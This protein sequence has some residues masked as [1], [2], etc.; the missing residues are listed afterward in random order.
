M[1]IFRQT[2]PGSLRYALLPRLILLTLLCWLLLLVGPFTPRLI[3]QTQVMAQTTVPAPTVPF[4]YPDWRI[5]PLIE[6]LTVTDLKIRR[7]ATE[8]LVKIGAPAVPALMSALQSP[9]ATLRWMAASVIGDMGS[10]AAAAVPALIL[11]LQDPDPQVRLYTTIALGNIGPA[12]AAAIPELSVSLQDADP[13]VRVYAPLA[14]RKMGAA[15]KGVIPELIATLQDTNGRVRLNAAYALGEMGIEAVA[16]LPSLET[17]LSDPLPYVRFGA[18]KGLAGIAQGFQDQ[19]EQLST[20][21]L[22]RVI[23]D[24]T[25]VLKQVEDHPERFPVSDQVYLRRPLNALKAEQDSRFLG[26]LQE[27]VRKNR[28]VLGGIA[29]LIGLPSLWFAM[30]RFAPLRL[31]QLN[32]A[33]RPY[34]DLSLPVIG[35][36]LPLRFVLFLS[37]F[38]YHPRVLDAWVAESVPTVR[39]QFAQK[40][41][42]K[43]RACY[44]PLPVSLGEQTLPTLQLAQLR[45]IFE[46]QRSCLVIWGEGGLGKTSLACQIAQLALAEQPEQ[47]LCPHLMLPVLIEE[48]LREVEGKSALLEAIRGQLQ[49]LMDA[50]EPLCEELLLRL[51]RQRRILVIIDRFSELSPATQAAVQ[52][53]SPAFPINALILT[54]QVET[55]LGR[56]NKTSLTPQRLQPSQ[57][58]LFLRDYLRVRGGGDLT[59]ATSQ[60][61][62]KAAC[63]D[64]AQWLGQRSTTVLL[65]KLYAE[66]YLNCPSPHPQTAIPDLVLSYLNELNQDLT[67]NRLDNRTLHQAAKALAWACVQTGYTLQPIRRSEALAVLD[68][69]AGVLSPAE[70]LDYLEHRLKLVETIGVAQEQLQFGLDPLAM[71]LAAL[72]LTEQLG[73]DE[74]KWRNQFFKRVDQLLETDPPE[75]LQ[76]FIWTVQACYRSQAASMLHPTSN[77]PSPMVEKKLL[78]LLG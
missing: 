34:T 7:S 9:D 15:A 73:S 25:Q 21:K 77:A 31:L 64:F 12:A 37:W 28:W 19:A 54:S 61:S 40:Q 23:L 16:A 46:R 36:N 41:T 3:A 49:M 2:H 58:P 65:V 48:D 47:R 11:A 59:Q 6:K 22:N 78:G 17:L 71:G 5:V 68:L 44:V 35:L 52:P 1:Q 63:Q 75:T 20:L 38:H 56:V 62:F 18:L 66:Q 57:I 10:D 32:N 33:L 8:A 55:A 4:A 45:P 76:G 39:Q 70:L 53:E 50:A 24:F 13:M 30:L 72:L 51:L 14:L 43:D 74:G 42:V 60:A 27:W 26:R 67:A 29:Y 69:G